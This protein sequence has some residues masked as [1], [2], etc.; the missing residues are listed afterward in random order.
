MASSSQINRDDIIPSPSQEHN[1]VL[2]PVQNND[3]Q[4]PE[5]IVG[6]PRDGE[7]AS[8]FTEEEDEFPVLTERQSGKQPQSTQE[9]PVD[10]VQP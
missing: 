2:S 9:K 1:T 8:P 7:H 3:E 6:D 10:K 5:D 4:M